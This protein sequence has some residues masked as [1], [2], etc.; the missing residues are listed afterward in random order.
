M[1]IFGGEMNKPIVIGSK[2]SKYELPIPLPRRLRRP[3]RPPIQL[4]DEA[5]LRLMSGG[6]VT[7]RDLELLQSIWM[8]GVMQSGQIRRLLFH[9]FK[10]E[11]SATV[12]VNRRLNF[13]YTEY[14]LNRIITALGTEPIYSLDIQGARL[15]QMMTQSNAR[16]DIHWSPKD[17]GKMLFFLKHRLG[18]TEFVVSLVEGLRQHGG[19]LEWLNETMIKLIQRGDDRPKFVPDGLGLMTV[20]DKAIP[21]FLEWDRGTETL[22]EIGQKIKN[23]YFY[24]RWEEI[25]RP[26]L[27]SLF[28]ELPTLQRFPF[29]IFVTTGGD[30][31]LLNMMKRIERVMA[32]YT[33]SYQQ[34]GI[35]GT[36]WEQVSEYGLLGSV[37]SWAGRS[38][39]D[40][41]TPGEG[42]SLLTLID[43][44]GEAVT[45]QQYPETPTEASEAMVGAAE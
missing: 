37:F 41:I 11:H 38:D 34:L 25:W 16:R 24:G 6:R 27:L 42:V 3:E 43:R 22:R 1:C 10:N 14:C 36:T 40:Q 5:A 32:N 9:T 19:S 21:I 18:V 13:L 12:A 29:V 8:L 23:Y 31:R 7:T 44:L 26:Y 28:P 2:D 4:N 17:Q 30:R 33:V 39:L 45:P 35:W 20:A 15:I